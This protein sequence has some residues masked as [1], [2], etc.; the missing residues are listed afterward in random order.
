MGRIKPNNKGLLS[1]KRFKFLEREK[2]QWLKGLPM[3]MAI[4]LEEDLLSSALI[5]EWRKKFPLDNP[6]CLKNILKKKT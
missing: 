2:K 4:S 6:I 5:W 1:K 3:K